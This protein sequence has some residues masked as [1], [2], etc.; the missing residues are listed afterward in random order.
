MTAPDWQARLVAP[1]FVP[2]A[3]ADIAYARGAPPEHLI[4]RLHLIGVTPDGSVLVCRSIE[5]WRFLPGGTREPGESVR[6]LAGRELLEEA[7]AV[8]RTEPVVFAAHAATSRLPQPYRPHQPHPYAYWAY[9][10]GQVVVSGPPT[11]PPDGE[12]IVAVSELDP[13]AAVTE[14]E[15]HDVLHADVLRDAIGRGLVR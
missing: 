7:G 9:A 1:R 10:V 14:L 4:S 2:Y 12:Q 5:G 3:G 11:N 13:A 8:F 15:S 6:E